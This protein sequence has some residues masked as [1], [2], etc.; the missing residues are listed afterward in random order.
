[1]YRFLRNSHLFLGVA[2]FLFVLMYG[3]SA[4]QMAHN[5]WFSMKP[6]VMQEHRTLRPD[7]ENDPRA[8]VRELRRNGV[9]GELRQALAT[10]AGWKF[11]IACPG[12]AYEVEYSAATH[13]ARI[14]VRISGFMAILN[15]IHHIAGT[16]HDFGPINGWGVFVALVSVALILL[17][18]TGIYLWF[19]IHSERV[20][21]I[22]LLAV[23][24]GVCVTLLVLI[25]TA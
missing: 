21:G 25:R 1:M 2:A 9:R 5:S 10:A 20:V 19:K 6:T 4:V 24:L 8:I 22:A 17:G 18:V 11:E 12:A 7:T 15:R 13:Q 3:L 23:N 16:W 14:L